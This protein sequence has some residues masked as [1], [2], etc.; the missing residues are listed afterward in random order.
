MKEF[1][2]YYPSVSNL[3]LADLI[4]QILALI[5]MYSLFIGWIP[6]FSSTP[7][8]KMMMP[9]TPYSLDLS[10]IEIKS[11]LTNY[12]SLGTSRNTHGD[13][14]DANSHCLIRNGKPWLPI[15]GEFHFSRYPKEGWEEALLKM[16]AGGIEVI[17]T[18]I[19]W[20]HHEEQKSVWKWDEN[21]DLRFF[22][23]LCQ[24]HN[25]F[26]FVRIGPW[27]HGEVRNG[28]HPDWLLEKCRLRQNNRIYMGYTK[29]LYQKIH[30]QLQ[31]FYFKEDGP[32]IGAQI[33]N[34]RAFDNI[35][36][37]EYMLAL[38]N[39]AQESG[40][41][42]PFYT[43]TGWQ[44][45]DKEQ[46]ELI[47]V[48]GAYPDAPWARGVEEIDDLKR[49][50]HFTPFLHESDIGNDLLPTRKKMGTY[51]EFPFPVLTAEMGAGTQCT[52]HR[53]PIYTMFDGPGLIIAKIG[54]GANGIGYYVFH[55]G[56]NPIG[57]FS[58]MQESK[59]THYPNDLPI[60]SYD[61]YA[62]LGEWGQ[63]RP[64]YKKL[65]Q[66][67]MFLQEWGH[68]LAEYPT[69]F[70]DLKPTTIKD[71]KTL[72][73]VVRSNGISG[74]LFINHYQRHLTMEDVQDVQFRL[75]L[76]NGREI[77]F[78][79]TPTTIL[80]Q[81][82][83]I[84]PFNLSIDQFSLL[85]STTQPYCVLRNPTNSSKTFVMCAF[86]GLK[87]ELV[88]GDTNIRNIAGNAVEISKIDGYYKV[89]IPD[90]GV[91][92][93][94]SLEFAD[95]AL[96]HILVL[97]QEQILDAWKITLHGHDY[98]FLS[99]ATIFSDGI[100]VAIQSLGKPALDLLVYPA[101]SALQ[102]S[103]ISK[104]T[105]KL[106]GLFAKYLIEFPRVTTSV[107]WHEATTLTST[108]KKSRAPKRPSLFSPFRCFPPYDTKLARVDGARY[109][110]VKLSSDPFQEGVSEVF[111]N[112]DY[113]G[114]S[115]AAYLNGILIAD[116]FYAGEPMTIGLRRFNLSIEA[117]DLVLLI[118][119]LENLDK[120]Y[121]ETHVKELIVR[122][123]LNPKI[124]NIE[125]IPQYKTT[126]TI[127]SA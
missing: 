25:L 17:A 107:Q 53:R 84:L 36:G 39:M 23:S 75:K 125:I 24:K 40:I 103:P 41:D 29:N 99:E 110:R 74:F 50:F 32:V 85:Y 72:R 105:K 68:F 64:S 88:V 7:L 117:K 127:T 35:K 82:I 34:E 67:H 86:P 77:I 16:K 55:G 11:P 87:A 60:I 102:F 104:T 62:P 83:G 13:Y 97:N 78:P 27:C 111:L 71:K 21:C 30:Q 19:F 47:P 51:D 48:W 46:K 15:M 12:I 91:D 112:I 119:P 38:K 9:D 45:Y 124:K 109:W 113:E 61:F 89:V 121:L 37:L 116:N 122:K 79:E 120:I 123:R 14:F 52:H 54:S 4:F 18:Y 43:A 65:K 26:L 20:I 49:S 76:Q 126:F 56:S 70:P 10:K 108:L 8:S 59:A 28:G 1:F 106:K 5:S 115:Q 114:D 57:K 44:G 94:I 80:G 96:W 6:F 22:A 98:L 93:E 101:D 58:T 90:P 31:G 92:S 63:I 73:W 95:G 66:I 118:T 100:S 69:V 33:E 81:T 3:S 42:V 2:H